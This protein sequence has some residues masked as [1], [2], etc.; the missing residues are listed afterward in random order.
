MRLDVNGAVA[1]VTLAVPPL[2]IIGYDLIASLRQTLRSLRKAPSIGIV[3]F[4]SDIP[5]VFSA[6]VDVKIHEP[7]EASRMLRRFHALLGDIR[8]NRSIFIAEVDG[9]C[10]GGGFELALTCDFVMASHRSTFGF[11]EINLGCFPPAG[12]V[13]LS[14]MPP[15]LARDLILT[16][17][18]LTAA[19]AY[20]L[21]LI[22]AADTVTDTPV[23]KLIDTLSSKS[24]T[25]LV[26]AK[27]ALQTASRGGFD[28]ALGR[29]ER[30]YERDVIPSADATEGVTAFLE[31]RPPKWT[32]R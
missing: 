14:R 5:N 25:A 22:S 28:T 18:T 19:D 6:G 17:R 13:L 21:G 30:I 8:K 24:Q 16:G 32:H 29:T 10:L 7:A 3:L 26:A 2:N 9:V 1:T 11:P 31:K 15:P 27:R 20:A 23:R 4:R 12:A